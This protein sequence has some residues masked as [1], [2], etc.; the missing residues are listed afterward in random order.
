MQTNKRLKI[1]AAIVVAISAL[2]F[3]LTQTYASTPEYQWSPFAVVGL[4]LTVGIGIIGKQYF[5]KTEPMPQQ[6]TR[7]TIPPRQQSEN[8]EE[9]SQEALLDFYNRMNNGGFQEI[10]PIS[11]RI[12]TAVKPLNEQA[13]DEFARLFVEALKRSRMDLKIAGDVDLETMTPEATKIKFRLTNRGQAVAQQ[14]VDNRPE[15]QKLRR[16]I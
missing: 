2:A 12:P 1:E 15:K 13:K 7:N 8:K 11:P 10:A 3:Y 9:L 14:S 16:P 5:A 4:T 6:E